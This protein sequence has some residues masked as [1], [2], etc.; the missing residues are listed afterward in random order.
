MPLELTTGDEPK[1]SAALK[2]SE[3][4]A[5]IKAVK[6]EFS[7]LRAAATW[8][9]DCAPP[10]GAKILPSGIILKLKRDEN[11]QPKRFKAR[12]VARGNLQ[13]SFTYDIELYAP[14]A[15]IESVRTLLAVAI[16]KGWVTH[17]LDIKGAFL[18]ASL[19]D[20]DEIYVRL[21]V[22]PGTSERSG[23]VVKLLKS[24]YGLRQA[25]KLWYGHL[26]SAL[27]RMG[28]KRSRTTDCLFSRVKKTETVHLLVY[29][30]D[31]LMVGTETAVSRVKQELARRFTTSDLG[32]CTH[33]LG[34]KVERRTNGLF[35]SQ[36]A[37]AERIVEKAGMED[38][39][40]ANTPLPL[41][42]P[43]YEE[44]TGTSDAE[45]EF[46]RRAPYR[47]LLGSLLFLAT[48]TRPDIATA[49]S[50]LAKFQSDPSIKHWKTL[51]TLIRYVKGT[52]GTGILLPGGA[53]VALTAWSD[54]DWARDQ[55]RRRSRSGYLLTVNGGPVVWSSK[56]QNA[57][58]LSTTEAEFYALS[59]CVRDV[60]W[61]RAVLDELQGHQGKPTVI[62]QD[63]LGTIRWT[64]DVQGLRKVKHI[65][66]RYHFVRDAV[67]DK[68]VTVVYTE[69]AKN[70]AD[71]LT[72]ILPGEPFGIHR[73]WL[74][75]Y[76]PD[77]L[78]CPRGG[79]SKDD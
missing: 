73:R 40:V 28:F 22:I 36:K 2:S 14:V 32:E 51:K 6:E 67:E 38:A 5:W 69:S 31:L 13:D 55:S 59:S 35:L 33:F 57:T 7:T 64:E 42:H 20:T 19:A 63:N 65:G 60:Q 47:Q 54:A 15:C 68:D 74:G 3:R 23:K 72:K 70:R 62:Y 76:A 58:T 16:A 46:M 66:I 17:H 12:L 75:C 56:L 27:Q 53:G 10:P 43:L 21:P 30:D 11:G 45:R 39:K 79:V 49:V 61:M 8:N 52:T 25:P 18:Y 4:T 71:S 77:E 29:V 9:E 1:L 41:S 78:T 37:Y 50:M 44:R 24:L 34:I 26:A 48:R